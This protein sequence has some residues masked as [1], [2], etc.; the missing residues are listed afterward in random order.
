MD[1]FESLRKNC[2]TTTTTTSKCE[3]I[4]GLTIPA[5]LPQKSN[6]IKLSKPLWEQKNRK[7]AYKPTQSDANCLL[8]KIGVLEKRIKK[9][10]LGRDDKFPICLFIKSLR[11]CL[12]PPARTFATN[13]T[14]CVY[15]LLLLWT[16]KRLF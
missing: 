15:K 2:D 1:A 5:N 14:D 3:L 10:R 16:I 11:N 4:F 9:W 13:Q 12:G 8:N 7:K 6:C